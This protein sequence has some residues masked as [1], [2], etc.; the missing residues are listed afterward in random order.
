MSKLSVDTPSDMQ[1]VFLRSRANGERYEEPTQ[2][3]LWRWPK[4]TA[5]QRR[6]AEARR[7]QR[8]QRNGMSSGNNEGSL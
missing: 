4:D 3:T 7:R 6:L 2:G 1:M 8:G 5:F